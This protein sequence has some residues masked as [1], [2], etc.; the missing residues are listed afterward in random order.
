MLDKTPVVARMQGEYN[1]VVLS[2]DGT[3]P[4]TSKPLQ[5]RLGSF[6]FILP[7]LDVA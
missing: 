2:D 6:H 1:F 7:A 5:A 3:T 4:I